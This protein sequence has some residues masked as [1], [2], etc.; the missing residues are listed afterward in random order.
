M[1][2]KRLLAFIIDCFVLFVCYALV[3]M[4]STLFT[5]KHLDLFIALF[6]TVC[7]YAREGFTGQGLGKRLLQ[8]EVVPHNPIRL[9]LRNITLLLWPLELVFFLICGKRIGD[10][11]FKCH[12]VEYQGK[13]P[14][15]IHNIVL[16]FIIIAIAT[17]LL[18]LGLLN[19]PH[20]RDTLNLLYMT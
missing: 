9:F 17:I 3:F 20:M 4:L 11:L 16:N 13:K 1:K 14:L 12:V 2:T 6:V 10:L 7:F 15:S 8:L 5:I 18:Y 19:L